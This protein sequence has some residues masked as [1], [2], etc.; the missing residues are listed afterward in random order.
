MKNS[1]G[2][3]TTNAFL[4]RVI[5]IHEELFPDLDSNRIDLISIRKKDIGLSIYTFR[6]NVSKLNK[7][8]KNTF[9]MKQFA[10][11]FEISSEGSRGAKFYGIKAP[12]EK[13]DNPKMKIAATLPK[14]QLDIHIIFDI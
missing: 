1:T 2:F 11:T 6:G 7:K 13:L 10:K 12:K 8:I 9:T 4:D 5:E 3:N 14:F